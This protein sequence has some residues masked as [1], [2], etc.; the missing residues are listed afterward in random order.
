MKLLVSIYKSPKKNEMY[1]Y[2]NRAEKLEA[3][4]EALK[5]VFGKPVHV[6]DMIMTKERKLARVDTEKVIS[7]LQETGYFL[8]MP[9]PEDEYI[10]H[11]PDEL[12][13]KNDPI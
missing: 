6:M 5:A 7:S 13:T 1:L 12:L 4:P 3:V 11:L 2:L 9:P 8:Q 10:E